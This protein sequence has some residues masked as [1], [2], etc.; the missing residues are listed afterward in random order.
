MYKYNSCKNVFIL[1]Y[2]SSSTCLPTPVTTSF[3]YIGAI[4]NFFSLYLSNMKP[5]NIKTL[6]D[7]FEETVD[8]YAIFRY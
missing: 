7:L 2:F 3:T 5:N 4:W 6:P 1:L 8:I